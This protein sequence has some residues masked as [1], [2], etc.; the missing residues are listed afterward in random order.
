MNKNIKKE[1]MK[2]IAFL[3]LMTSNI[4]IGHAN[5]ADIKNDIQQRYDELRPIYEAM[6]KEQHRIIHSISN[7]ETDKEL[8][9]LKESPETREFLQTFY[10][11]DPQ[12]SGIRFFQRHFPD[13]V[14]DIHG[15]ERVN[16]RGSLLYC[17]KIW[18]EDEK[19][20]GALYTAQKLDR[21]LSDENHQL[22]IAF[23]KG[24]HKF[25]AWFLSMLE[26]NSHE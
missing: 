15:N 6:L 20:G 23:H 24:E 7:D 21:L 16:S 17:Y 22:S 18:L 14:F 13:S 8:K 5:P 25:H 4:F 11:L 2:K 12:A 10:I 19:Y 9:K 3:F 1:Y 26:K